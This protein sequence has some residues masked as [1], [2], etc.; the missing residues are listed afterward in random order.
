MALLLA[1]I[2]RMGKRVDSVYVAAR[3]AGSEFSREYKETLAMFA[4][5]SAHVISNARRHRDERR[6][7]ADPRALI[8]TSLMGVVVFGGRK[9]SPFSVD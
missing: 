3:E 4:S 6:G 9:G 8:D 5:Q 1:A 2:L 7:S